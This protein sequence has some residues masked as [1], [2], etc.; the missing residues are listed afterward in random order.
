MAK[1]DDAIAQEELL[2]DTEI[3]REQGVKPEKIFEG[4]CK[5]GRFATVASDADWYEKHDIDIQ[6]QFNK[7]ARKA[8]SSAGNIADTLLRN[9]QA[10]QE[11]GFDARRLLENNLPKVWA[12]SGWKI[13]SQ[14]DELAKIGVD[15][16]QVEEEGQAYDAEMSL[17][18]QAGFENPSFAVNSLPPN[19]NSE[20]QQSIKNMLERENLEQ[21]VPI[22]RNFT[23]QRWQQLQRSDRERAINILAEKLSDSYGLFCPY[24][25]RFVAKED[26]G[27]NGRSGNS[28]FGTCHVDYQP[29]R[30]LEMQECAEKVRAAGIDATWLPKSIININEDAIEN[31]A[32][33]AGTIAHE[34]RHAFQEE[35]AF[36]YRRGYYN[37]AE[38]SDNFEQ[39]P[40]LAQYYAAN[41]QREYYHES[42]DSYIEYRQQLVE[43]DAFFLG[44]RY[45]RGV[46]NLTQSMAQRDNKPRR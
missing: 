10:Y 13:R 37:Q 21:T 45:Q 39:L 42:T 16:S 17:G 11:A 35:Q 7:F 26:L 4:F 19:V 41:L 5:E 28:V 25:V 18:H 23:L 24:E 15:I 36:L 33:L 34:M 1:T 27:N 43:Y 9:P 2:R 12:Q 6:E 32:K 44:D 38:P 40:H 29:A 8:V 3:L 30:D 20:W 31:G 46:D 14:V 22:L